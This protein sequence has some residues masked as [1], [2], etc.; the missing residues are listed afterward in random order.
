MKIYHNPRCRK[1]RAGLQYALDHGAEV[2]VIDYMR[3]LLQPEEIKTLLQQLNM[4]AVELIRTQEEMYR[5][6]LKGK[7]FT[8]DEWIKIMSENPKLIRRPILVKGHR[9]IIADPPD[10]AEVL[11]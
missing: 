4:K 1:S 6:E 9:A 10:Q 8:E 3:L 5:K 7:K 11:F 2:E